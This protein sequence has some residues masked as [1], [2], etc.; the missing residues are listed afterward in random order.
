MTPE[1][2]RKIL[3]ECHE[4]F[5]R[6]LEDNSALDKAAKVLLEELNALETKHFQKDGIVTDHRDV[7]AHGPRLKAVELIGSFYGLK[8]PEKHEHSGAVII[9]RRI[10]GAEPTKEGENEQT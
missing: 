9:E 4:R 5:L 2:G 3:D 7:I 10:I 8:A 6:S 1:Q